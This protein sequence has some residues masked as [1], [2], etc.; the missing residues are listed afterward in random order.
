MSKKT[1]IILTVAGLLFAMAG[2][3]MALPV[4][5]VPDAGSSVSLM[6]TALLALAGVR[7]FVA[8]KS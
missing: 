6:G 3:A 1:T 8:K 5:H 4:R 2:S 7:M